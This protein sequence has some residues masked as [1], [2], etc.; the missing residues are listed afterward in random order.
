[1]FGPGREVGT[2]EETPSLFQRKKKLI[3]FILTKQTHTEEKGE[4]TKK[5]EKE[6]NK[7]RAREIAREEY[8]RQ[9]RTKK[10]RNKERN[11]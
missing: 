10:Q 7:E 9:P 6:K 11:E 5:N 2:P 4:G 3:L 1:V 8:L